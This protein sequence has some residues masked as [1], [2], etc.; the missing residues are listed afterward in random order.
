MT[1]FA[2]DSIQ[3]LQS[4]SQPPDVIYLDPMFPQRQ[5]SGLVKKKFQL[6]QQLERPCTDGEA[7]L[8]A[9][10]AAGARKIVIKRPLKGEL[11][12]GRTPDYSLKGKTIRYDCL[13]LP[14]KP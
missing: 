3:A 14:K 13:V 6:L 7:L 1:L 2:G 8:S 12:G 9:A 4:L 10:I 11:L 5:K